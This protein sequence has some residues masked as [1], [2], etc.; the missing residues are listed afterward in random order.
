MADDRELDVFSLSILLVS[1]NH[2]KDIARAL[3][4]VFEQTLPREL[5]PIQI[6][7]ADDASTDQTLGIVRS[8]D[9]QD[10]RFVFNYLP[11]Q[12]NLGITRN[13][14][15]GF[16]ACKGKYIAVLEG[17]DYWSSSEK[18][19]KQIQVLD[20]NPECALCSVN[21]KIYYEQDGTFKPRISCSKGWRNI[22]VPELIADNIIGNFSTCMYRRSALVKIP[23]E[24]FD[25]KSYD[26]ILNILVGSI[27][28]IIFLHEPLSVYRVHDGGVWSGLERA[29]KIKMHMDAIPSY[30]ALT[31]G[32][33]QAEFAAL[34]RT[35]ERDYAAAYKGPL[36]RLWR[37]IKVGVRGKSR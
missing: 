3:K 5:C 34:F 22:S 37:K 35:L 9:G 11:P 8:F 19:S 15:R 18:L 1:F 21:C 36:S 33:Y 26:W 32:R 14:Q 10:S 7:V 16:A 25:I 30:D 24:T 6:V 29:S 13:Y 17:D 4:S 31:K 12:R 23:T 20:Q 27:G 28:E 2:E